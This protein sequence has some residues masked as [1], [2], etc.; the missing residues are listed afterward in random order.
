MYPTWCAVPSVVASHLCLE[1]GATERPVSLT[2]QVPTTGGVCVCVMVL[3]KIMCS[4]NIWHHTVRLSD[5][6]DNVHPFDIIYAEVLE[7]QFAC[8]LS[9]R[10]AEH[11]CVFCCFMISTLLPTCGP[12]T[13][14]ASSVVAT[15]LCLESGSTARPVSLTQQVPTTGGACVRVC[16]VWWHMGVVWCVGVCA[17]VCVH[18]W[19]GSC[20]V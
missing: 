4:S 9:T 2:K 1:S 16:V 7:C 10:L 6:I 12:H 17:C 20:G 5:S 13:T 8:C 15:H 18:A 11:C 19:C 3:L 14:P